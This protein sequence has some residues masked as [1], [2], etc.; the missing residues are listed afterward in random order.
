VDTTIV[1]PCP[2]FLHACLFGIPPVFCGAGRRRRISRCRTTLRTHLPGLGDG[3]I[4]LGWTT[5]FGR[6]TSSHLQAS[7]LDDGTAR[8][9][10]TSGSPPP[11]LPVQTHRA[12]CNAFHRRRCARREKHG[13]RGGRTSAC[14]TGTSA[15]TWCAYADRAALS[16]RLRG[17]SR[18]VSASRPHNGVF[19]CTHCRHPTCAQN[20]T[21][22]RFRATSPRHH[23]TRALHACGRVGLWRVRH[24]LFPARC[25][26]CCH[27]ADTAHTMLHHGHAGG[28]ARPAGLWPGQLRGAAPTLTG[29]GPGTRAHHAAATRLAADTRPTRGQPRPP[30]VRCVPHW[31]QTSPARHMNHEHTTHSMAPPFPYLLGRLTASRMPTSHC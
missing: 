15:A 7:G 16:T 23:Y 21:H 13:F 14:H 22:L 10:E 6:Q 25:T 3:R 28:R 5:G 27:C 4:I 2:A 1:L 18:W 8:D 17:R 19:S 12:A 9:G 26:C 11:P 30:A 31:L 29:P 20:T 24:L